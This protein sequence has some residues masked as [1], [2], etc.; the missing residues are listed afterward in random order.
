MLGGRAECGG[1]QDGAELAAVQRGGVRLVV[2]PGAA[3]VRRRGAIQEFFLNGVLVEA[4]DGAQAPG[5]GGACAAPGFKSTGEGLDVGAA[6]GEQ[7]QGAGTAPGRELPQVQ[8]AGVAGEAAV[9]G[10]EPGKREALGVSERRLDGDER[11]RE[12]RGCHRATPGTARTQD[13]GPYARTEPPQN[14]GG[15]AGSTY[16]HPPCRLCAVEA[17]GVRI[18]CHAQIAKLWARL[19][20][21]VAMLSFAC[22]S[23]VSVPGRSRPAALGY[24]GR[25]RDVV[26]VSYTHLRA[27]ETRH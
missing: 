2:Q 18:P 27:H 10:Q 11:S 8:G 23:A 19:V 21:Q 15:G 24:S 25:V 4:R 7:G 13:P 5:H 3:H 14:R 20:L 17:C 1:D 16:P 22:P 6:G 26:S 9:P 12:S